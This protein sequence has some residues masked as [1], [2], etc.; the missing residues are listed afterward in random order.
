MMINEIEIIVEAITDATRKAF[1]EL[2]KN[3]EKYYYCV[4]FFDMLLS[5]LLIKP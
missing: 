4:L 2:L 3:N 5:L 1:I